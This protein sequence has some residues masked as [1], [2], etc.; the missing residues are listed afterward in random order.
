M[1]LRYYQQE[2][3]DKTIQYFQSNA[4]VNQNPLIVAPTGT[5]K[6]HMIAG[7]CEQVLEKWGNMRILILAHRKEL[8]QQNA[9]K[10]GKHIH[11]G[12]YSAGLNKKDIAQVTLSTI[13]TASRA[14]ERFGK[15]NLLI[16]D[17]AHLVPRHKTGMYRGLIASLRL[18]NP[19]LRV[20]GYTAT[21][22]RLDSGMLVAKNDP[23]SIFTDIVYNIEIDK[24]I[25]EGFICPIVGKQPKSYVDTSNIKKRGGE[26]IAGEAEN[27]F[28]P[29]IKSQVNDIIENSEGRSSWLI[30]CSG[31]DHANLVAS[32]LTRRGVNAA[33]ITG[34][35]GKG[36][37]AEI[38]EKF[39][40]GKI[41]AVTNC[42]VLTTGFDAPNIDLIA[43]LRPT[44][45]TG[46][47]VQMVGRGFR[48]HPE[49][50]NCLLLDFG[51]N[52]RRHGAINDIKINMQRQSVDKNTQVRDCA[53]CNAIYSAKLLVCPEC[54]QDALGLCKVC[55]EYVSIRL[56]REKQCC[57]SCGA[58]EVT[59]GRSLGELV[60][61]DAHP[62]LLGNNG[63]YDF[64]VDSV[65]W[66]IHQKEGKPNSMKLAFYVKESSKPI[67]HFLCPEHGEWQRK[68]AVKFI[69][70]WLGQ[71]F[72]IENNVGSADW[73][74]KTQALWRL[75][76]EFQGKIP[77]PK[78]IVAKKDGSGKYFEIVKLTVEKN[79]C[80]TIQSEIV[81]MQDAVA[82]AKSFSLKSLRY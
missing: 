54:K 68:F 22:Y 66:Y 73:Q 7:L 78:L 23:D 49:K 17:E 62:L 16:I 20:V 58:R 72:F 2:S 1:S 60:S 9:M 39:K 74:Y 36:D 50:S 25:S 63:L 18:I 34:D 41:Q 4:D 40:A 55:D 46:L 44:Q 21:P 30:F 42:D 45:S 32:E 53:S 80:H 61:D 69:L 67:L 14:Y 8:I 76:E 3:I 5:G 48:I 24:M 15:V 56:R 31:I 19:R 77:L 59:N 65:Q 79:P 6:S 13:G 28:L 35:T 29:H 12:L 82:E 33:S 51:E 81:L 26:F 11:V 71:K 10:L 47:Y 70:G 43:L 27:T 37:R 52:I 64:T 75:F 38:L 57:P